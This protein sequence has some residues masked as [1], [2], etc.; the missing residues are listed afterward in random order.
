VSNLALLASLAEKP[1]AK[2][3]P[4]QAVEAA[5]GTPSPSSDA[6]VESLMEEFRRAPDSKSALRSLRALLSQLR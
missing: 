4:D 5:P 6:V 2:A 1:A 3:D